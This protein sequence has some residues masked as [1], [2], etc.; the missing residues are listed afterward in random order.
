[1]GMMAKM[2]S[3]AP[4]FIITVGGLFVLFMVL[5]DA[6]ISDVIGRRSNY[7]GTINGYEVSYQE[8]SRY[9]ETARQNQVAQ[10]GQEIDE[11]QMDLFRDQVWDIIVNQ[12]LV[13]EKIEELGI[14]VT[15]DEI[16]DVLLGDNPPQFLINNFIDST[17]AFNRQ[18]YEAALFNPSNKEILVQLEE[19]VSQQKIQEKLQ[20]YLSASI[21]VSEGEI[22]RAFYDQAVKMNAEYLEISSSSIKDSMISYTEEDLK[23]YY[24]KNKEDF[25]QKQQ[26]KLK[27]VLFENIPS[28]NDS[29]GIEKN[30]K[31]IVEKLADDTSNFKTYV[32]IYSDE[33]YSRDSIALTRLSSNVADAIYEAEP[34]K[35]VGPLLS[36][37]AYYLYKV[38][39]RVNS[40][41]M[42]VKARHILVSFKETTKDSAY[43]KAMD[44]YRRV[45]S[46]GEDFA[47]VAAKESDDPGS[48]IKGG[49]LGWFGK[50]QMVKP[51]E[52]ASFKGP[53]GKVQK[54]IESQFGYHIIQV[55]S[56]T[57]DL[58]VVE[59]IV[60]N[61]KASAV[62]IDKAY[63][64]AG[65][66]A[67]LAEDEGF[68]KVAEQLGLKTF[69]TVSFTDENNVIPG[70]GANKALVRFAFDNSVGNIGTVFKVRKGYL[71]P[72]I[73]ENIEEGFNPFEEVENRIKNAVK[74]Q[75]KIEKTFEIASQIKKELGD[76]ED[77][78]A[79]E[80]LYGNAKFGYASNF[81]RGSRIEGV[82]NEEYAFS[83]YAFDAEL[84]KISEPIEG[85]NASY[86]IKVTYRTKLDDNAY[87]LQRG[88]FLNN[89]LD[90]KRNTFFNQWVQN[91]KEE[92]EI[93]DERY[94][95]YR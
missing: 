44:I 64:D 47:A 91:L 22:E 92:A 68:D 78:K 70:L 35:L 5:S 16:R 46:G 60:N 88:G 2:R 62:T 25:A 72:M 75:K 49:E 38:Y 65:D 73:T 90:Q 54:P 40:N 18:A 7:V 67:Y 95:F 89:L 51:F 6:R 36:N 21:T 76:T 28:K 32:E 31:A 57:S 87:T 33:P 17:G 10:T 15:P 79:G 86:L 23:K 39:D 4:W 84:N 94:L 8:Y 77:L 14:S 85:K 93:V 12:R 50:G 55:M 52:E 53:V 45:T 80:K 20:S 13:E 19:Q 29:L 48:K 56:R 63:N 1:M 24:E 9:V 42:S 61:I 41:K 34:G 59:N 26:R 81:T 83:E 69:E 82:G 71:V 11:S 66:F 58:F 43:A 74:K 37:N 3:L 30:L 27:Y